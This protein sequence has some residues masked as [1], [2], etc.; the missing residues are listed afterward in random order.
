MS[1]W[2]IFGY[3]LGPLSREVTTLGQI[4]T[5]ASLTSLN[6]IQSDNQSK[7]G[8]VYL[9]HDGRLRMSIRVY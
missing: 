4:A 1:N 7:S 2:A 5:T 6:G 8:L 3:Y 9:V